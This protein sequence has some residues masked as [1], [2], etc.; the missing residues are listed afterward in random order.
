M[1]K[2]SQL[3]VLFIAHPLH[4]NQTHTTCLRVRARRRRAVHNAKQRG[5]ALVGRVVG[6]GGL[7][8][9]NQVLELRV[10]V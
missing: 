6:R 5:E 1:H 8:T 10:C 9:D 3:L 7:Q 2:K 4:L